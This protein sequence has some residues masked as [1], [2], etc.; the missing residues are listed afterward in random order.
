MKPN[1]LQSLCRKWQKIL[2]LQDWDIQIKYVRHWEL[3]D[4]CQGNVIYKTARNEA[5]IKILVE[6]DYPDDYEGFPQDQEC[7]LVHELIHLKLPILNIDADAEN[8]ICEGF[9]KAFVMLDRT[10]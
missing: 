6:S 3:E 8:Q 2:R 7:T 5:V 1:E 4:N 10:K 9:S